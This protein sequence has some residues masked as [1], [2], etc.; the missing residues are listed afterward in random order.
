VGKRRCNTSFSTSSACPPSC[1]NHPALSP[2]A[3]FSSC[4]SS[5]SFFHRAS[6]SSF[7]P[8]SF[9]FSLSSSSTLNAGSPSPAG[10]SFLKLSL[11][12]FDCIETE[13]ARPCGFLGDSTVSAA[14]PTSSSSFST[15]S[16]SSAL[17][18]SASLTAAGVD[19]S[20]S[21]FFLLAPPFFAFCFFNCSYYLVVS[22][23]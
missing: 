14:S 5:S 10:L 11:L 7:S 15:A 12:S 8:S 19:D 23:Y 13:G 6:A 1:F 22:S 18:S 3:S 16:A 21:S 17:V 4:S 2:L 9:L 20:A